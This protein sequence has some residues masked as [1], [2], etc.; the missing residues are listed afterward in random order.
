M[1][2]ITLWQP[3]ASLV[4]HG[5]KK[6]ETRSWAT[7]YRGP[8]V[9]H[10]AKRFTEQEKWYCLHDFKEQLVEGGIR[11]LSEI[12]LGAAL[13]VVDLVDVLPTDT[14]YPTISRIERKAGN[15]QAGRFAWKL[16]NL[17][18]FPE[19]VPMK[20]RQG[21]WTL[22]AEEMAHLRALGG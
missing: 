12:P 19:P 11:R 21:L 9:I 4:A 16:E 22:M 1:K 20:G 10:A 15:Y 5:F 18:P 7:T 17:R 8:L 3:W 6:F 14:V 2:A 13:C